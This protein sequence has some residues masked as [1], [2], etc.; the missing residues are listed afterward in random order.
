MFTGVDSAHRSVT[1]NVSGK[2]IAFTFSGKPVV[3]RRHRLCWRNLMRAG[4]KYYTLLTRKSAVTREPSLTR[5]FHLI[6]EQCE[7]V[8]ATRYDNRMVL[9]MP[10]PSAPPGLF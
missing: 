3:W 8:M 4:Q 2:A 10:T 9:A 5:S 6:E 7:C 1:E